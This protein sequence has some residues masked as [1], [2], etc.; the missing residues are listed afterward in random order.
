MFSIIAKNGA[1]NKK[2]KKIKNQR[3]G[4][5]FITRYKIMT[6]FYT[7]LSQNDRFM[8]ACVKRISS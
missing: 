1:M 3:T 8:H 6:I 5:L 2:E 4:P 7:A